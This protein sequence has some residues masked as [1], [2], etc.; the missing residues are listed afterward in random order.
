MSRRD[1]PDAS[2][3]DVLRDVTVNGVRFVRADDARQ[4]ADLLRAA[5]YRA[6]AWEQEAIALREFVEHTLNEYRER[7]PDQWIAHARTL[8]ATT[9]RDDA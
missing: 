8:L 6:D 9:G 7:M 2:T 1:A 4:R 3:S 5:N